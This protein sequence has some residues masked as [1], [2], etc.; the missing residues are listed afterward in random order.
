MSGFDELAEPAGGD[1]APAAA[2]VTDRD[3]PAAENLRLEPQ[4]LAAPLEPAAAPTGKGPVS[5]LFFLTKII[6]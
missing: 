5:N 6:Y 1:E 4:A 2:T 3:K